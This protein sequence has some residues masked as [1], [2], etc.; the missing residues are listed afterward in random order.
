LTRRP[1]W[2][3]TLPMRLTLRR[4][5]STAVT[6]R[7][8]IIIHRGREYEQ[9]FKEIAPVALDKN[10]TIYTL[11]TLSSAQPPPSMWLWRSRYRHSRRPLALQG[12]SQKR[13]MVSRKGRAT[14]ILKNDKGSLRCIHSHLSMEPGIPLDE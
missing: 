2:V 8:L 3:M 6:K 9:D 13:W 1:T 12:K 5:T 4:Q 11:S 14:L 10:I 7:N